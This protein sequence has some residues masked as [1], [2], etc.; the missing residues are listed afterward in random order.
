MCSLTSKTNVVLSQFKGQTQR[1]KDIAINLQSLLDEAV[2]RY[3]RYDVA[4]K[5]IMPD[6]D[7]ADDSD[8]D[9]SEDMVGG[10][11]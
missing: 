1:Y 4:T 8:M 7:D 3:G 5:N 6:A 11:M 2:E 9:E 10:N